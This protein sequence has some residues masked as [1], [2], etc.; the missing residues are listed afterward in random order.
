MR[1]HEGKWV[2]MPTPK[3]KPVSASKWVPLAHKHGMWIDFQNKCVTHV[4]GKINEYWDDTF[5]AQDVGA[6]VV[7]VA[8]MLSAGEAS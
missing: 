3:P 4:E 7:I 5:E 1:E 8:K 6:C 2:F